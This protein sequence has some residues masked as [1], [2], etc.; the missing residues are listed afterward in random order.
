MASFRLVDCHAS[1][2]NSLAHGLRLSIW[3]CCAQSS[4]PS[5]SSTLTRLTMAS[6]TDDT[7]PF[8]ASRPPSYHENQGEAPAS[9]SASA[10]A[11]ATTPTHHAPLPPPDIDMSTVTIIDAVKTTDHVGAS[12]FI[13]YVIRCGSSTEARRRY[14]EFEGLRSALVKL[15]PTLII[16][17]IPDK[18][19][20]G[21][22]AVKQSKAKEDATIIARI[23]R[24]LQSF[25]RRCAAH[26]TLQTDAVLRKFLD[27]RFTWH[28]ISTSP[29]LSH[30]PKSN[31]K[32]PPSNPADPRLSDQITARIA[33]LRLT[34]SDLV[35]SAITITSPGNRPSIRSQDFTTLLIE[36]FSPSRSHLLSTSNDAPRSPTGWTIPAITPG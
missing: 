16:P 20:L 22:Y 32:A 27:G 21:D 18:H 5:P 12:S 6:T 25:L 3:L 14:S 29:P 15:H 35:T 23:K 19:A 28:D 11:A 10:A 1:R 26:P 4:S 17:P 9:S 31:L 2:R 7:D 34:W 13:V 8:Q 33:T 36:T 30:L 24:M